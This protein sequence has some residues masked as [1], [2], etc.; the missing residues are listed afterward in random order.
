MSKLEIK[1]ALKPGHED[2]LDSLVSL[3][4]KDSIRI[5]IGP[6]KA[7]DMAFRSG[8]SQAIEDII[9][10]IGL[11]SFERKFSEVTLSRR[12]RSMLIIFQNRNQLGNG[13][14]H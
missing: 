13:Q 8:M 2:I 1:D 6:T 5:G 3:K 10:I 11:P 7:M 9:K 4:Y 12:S 14:L